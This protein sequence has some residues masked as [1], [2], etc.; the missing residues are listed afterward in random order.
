MRRVPEALGA[1]LAGQATTLA[2]CWKLTR[3][4]GP[5]LGFT[6]HDEPIAF[7]GVVF[8]AA[9]GLTAG[10][11]EASL[12]LAAASQEVEGA[13]SSL[14]IDEADIAAGRYD[15]ARIEIFLVNWQA[16]GQRLLLDVADLGEVKRGGPAFTAE[17][18]GIASRLD[19]R[20]GRIYRRRC[21]AVLGDG[22]CGVD[23][24]APAFWADATLAAIVSG[25]LIVDG[26]GSLDL[27]LY[28][29]GHVVWHSGGVAGQR[30]EIAGLQPAG[31]GLVRIALVGSDGEGAVPGDLLRLHAGC[32]KSFATC[33]TRFGNHLNFRGFPHLP[34]NDA[35]LG[36]AR[37][38][39]LNDGSPVVP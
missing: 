7:D 17:L 20:R 32:D 24:A 31:G 19:R 3:R 37:Q 36:F 13:L 33:R 38:D 16:P 28:A 5:V 34:G 15:G 30:M 4:D 29:A 35:A 9:T 21:D 22:R 27:S 25:A 39:G 6:D 10:E 8:E 14:A 11:A 23:I 1:H 18:R 2:S 26:I 12:G